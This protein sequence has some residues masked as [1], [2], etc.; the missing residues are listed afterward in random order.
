V[1]SSEHSSKFHLRA[2]A[3]THFK[4]I[5]SRVLKEDGVVTGCIVHWT[6]DVTRDPVHV[7]RTFRPESYAV[8]GGNVGGRFCDA[9]EFRGHITRGLELRPSFNGHS[10]RKPQGRE[11]RFV[12]GYYLGE[13]RH[14]QINV[15]DVLW[16]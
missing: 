11:Q 12:K 3:V 14:T 9:E 5:A 13:P 2:Q 1:G 8:F 4:A 16:S 7:R 10:A 6:F 15:I